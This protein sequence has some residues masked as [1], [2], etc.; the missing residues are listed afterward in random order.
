MILDEKRLTITKAGK[1]TE[2]QYNFP[3]DD[4]EILIT[5]IARPDKDVIIYFVDKEVKD[6]EG[7]ILV[8]T[9][10]TIL[11][12]Q[13]LKQAWEKFED[14]FEET[15]KE[16]NPEKQDPEIQILLV[17]VEK[18][19]NSFLF[20]Q[21]QDGSQQ[22]LLE[23]EIM[24]YDVRFTKP[25]FEKLDF[26]NDP[27]ISQPFNTIW[28]IA[29]VDDVRYADAE[30][31]CTT[32]IVALDSVNQPGQNQN[33]GEPGQE[34]PQEGESEPGDKGEP[35]EPQERQKGDDEGG[36]LSGEEGGSNATSF[37]QVEYKGV[38]SEISK[39]TGLSPDDVESSLRTERTFDTF[40]TLNNVDVNN[41][42]SKLNAGD[43]TRSQFAR[44]VVKDFQNS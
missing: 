35:G 20:L 31:D 10:K 42:K 9:D 4:K 24:N 13:D 28:N 38:I 23:L 11:E 18:T 41:L 44:Q 6:L 25:K 21:K 36:E 8:G 26:Q 7:N 33:E 15:D 22:L 3:S 29:L 14:L 37:S 30:S 19:G 27:N 2:Y 16:E 5:L 40:L 43:L 32:Y 34:Q 17:S 12:T 1:Y 39:Q